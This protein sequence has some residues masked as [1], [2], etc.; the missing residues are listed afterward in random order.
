MGNAGK[1]IAKLGSS[2]PN[3]II[4]MTIPTAA[5][6]HMHGRSVKGSGGKHVASPE[7]IGSIEIICRVLFGF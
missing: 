7:Q 6:H 5:Y 1:Y 2:H 3:S 4:W